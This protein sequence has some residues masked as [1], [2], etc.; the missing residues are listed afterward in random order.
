MP[1]NRERRLVERGLML[2]TAPAPA[3]AYVPFTRS[4]KILFI[5]GQVPRVRDKPAFIGILGATISLEEGQK[6]ARLCALNVMAQIKAAAGDLDQVASILRLVGY[7][8]STS[9]FKEHHKVM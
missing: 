7:V 9:D 1:G 6:A 3:A 8:A 4:G 2:P 5:A